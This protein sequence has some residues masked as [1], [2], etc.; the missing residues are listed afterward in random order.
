[1]IFSDSCEATEQIGLELVLC[2]IRRG[3]VFAP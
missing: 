2:C 1:L 3:S